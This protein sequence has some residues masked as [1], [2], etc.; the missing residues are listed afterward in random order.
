[1]K[2]MHVKRNTQMDENPISHRKISRMEQAA[3]DAKGTFQ[4]LVEPKGQATIT[5]WEKE[6][7]AKRKGKAWEELRQEAD[8]IMDPGTTQSRETLYHKTVE[9]AWRTKMLIGKVSTEKKA[10]SRKGNKAQKKLLKEIL[11]RLSTLDASTKRIAED[12]KNQKEKLERMAAQF[13][14][15]LCYVHHMD[16]TPADGNGAPTRIRKTHMVAQREESKDKAKDGKKNLI[17]LD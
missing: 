3:R 7:T 10:A 4:A 2:K 16:I 1:M 5:R 15:Y 12:Q 14:L 8:W 17:I 11:S 9:M 6:I 13:H